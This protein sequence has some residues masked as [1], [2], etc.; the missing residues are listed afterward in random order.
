MIKF[1]FKARDWKGKINKG[2][3]EARSQKEAVSLLKK[4]GLIV[5]E[6]KPQRKGLLS[7]FSFLFGR[8]GL[9]QISAF[10]RQ[11]SINHDQCRVTLN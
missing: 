1:T 3:V 9:K 8:I 11:L 5:I 6:V 2:M 10:T 4:R 7:E